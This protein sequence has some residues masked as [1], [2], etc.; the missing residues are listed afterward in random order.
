MAKGDRQSFIINVIKH[1]NVETQ[2]E[3]AELLRAEGYKATQATISRDIKALGLVKIAYNAN[4]K[5]G[6][7]YSVYVG[8][9]SDEENAKEKYDII[10]GMVLDVTPVNNL[11]VI[12]VRSGMANSVAAILDSDAEKDILGT[13]AGDDTILAIAGSDVAAVAFASKLKEKL[14]G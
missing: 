9:V 8:D 3:L 14:R 11:I 4:G 12:K 2:E 5:K 13:L 1:N 6:F 10:K 7:R